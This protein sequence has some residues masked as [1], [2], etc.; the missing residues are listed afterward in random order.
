M[1]DLIG[2]ETQD[3]SFVVLKQ[4]GALISTV[5][6][7]D[8]AKAAAKD[9]TAKR[10]MAEPNADHLKRIG[11]LIDAGKVK[12]VVAETYPLEDA[13]A[14]HEGLERAIPSARSC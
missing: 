6:E 14:A 2:G 12:V 7:P 4:V 1:F 9:L 5:Q 11:E 10:Y 3:R 13:R 8:K